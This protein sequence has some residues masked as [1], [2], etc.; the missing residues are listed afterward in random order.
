MRVFLHDLLWQQD[1]EGF[2]KRMDQFLTIA[3]KHHI[4]VMFVLLDGVWDPDPK[5]AEQREPRPDVHN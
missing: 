3:D 2:L 5:P 1:R 4:G